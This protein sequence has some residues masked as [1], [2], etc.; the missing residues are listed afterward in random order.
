MCAVA[1]PTDLILQLEFTVQLMHPKYAAFREHRTFYK[2][3]TLGK[4]KNLHHY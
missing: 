3:F 4:V 2:I 1:A